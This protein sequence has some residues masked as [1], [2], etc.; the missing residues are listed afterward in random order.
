MAGSPMSFSNE[1]LRPYLMVA[2]AVATVAL[3]FAGGVANG[4]AQSLGY[5][6]AIGLTT[7]TLAHYLAVLGDRQFYAALTLTLAIALS[8]TVLAT[9]VA[10]ATALVLRRSLW[11]QRVTTFIYQ[12]PLPT[13][14]LVAAAGLVMLLTQSGLVARV[15]F[16]SGLIA[17]PSDFPAIF[18]TRESLGIILV[19]LWKEA[20]FIG[21]V[22]LAMLK[23]IGLE[24]EE[25]ARTLGANAW[26]R[27]RFVLLP[28]LTPGMLATAIIVFAFMFG[29]FE[30]PL[31][32]GVRH[33]EVLPVMAYRAYIDPDLTAR[34]VAMVI[35]MLITAIVLLLL[36][37]YRRLAH[38]A[39]MN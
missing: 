34:P 27:F 32:L 39:G 21:L 7:L 3:L 15:A 8:S 29:S 24:Y 37:L 17:Q 9:L 35:G 30:V 13:P 19:Y 5:F 38:A 33:P 20:P 2:P 6:P 11:G 23:G 26:Q 4:L 16:A 31:L 18:Y 14:H 25:T 10:L 22:L 12:I 36:A 1:R 28:L